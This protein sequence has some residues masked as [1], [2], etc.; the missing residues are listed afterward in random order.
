MEKKQMEYMQFKERLIET[1]QKY[2]LGKGE[3]Y[4]DKVKKT[5]DT[6]KEAVIVR[7]IGTAVQATIYPEDMYEGYKYT[8]DFEKCMKEV[9]RACEEVPFVDECYIPKTWESAK[10]RLHMRVI[11]RNW[12][13]EGL[14]RMP[15]R[16]YMDLA[17]VFY[18]FIK[19]EGGLMA[20]LP[21]S[22]E[23]MK[24]WGVDVKTLWE[25]S[26]K[27]LEEEVFRIESMEAAIENAMAE[28]KDAEI[29]E[30]FQND[31]KGMEMEGI[32]KIYVVTNQCR[33]YGARVILRKDLLRG[34]AKEQGGSFYILPCSV[35]EILLL[36]EDGRVTAENLKN[37]VYEIN[38]CSSTPKNKFL[39]I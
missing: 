26:R 21:V 31:R 22:R 27:N 13:K 24:L 7:L 35:H 23:C 16:E 1:L 25:A 5:N 28:M 6:D 33:N 20:T 12:N 36:K 19:E 8:G 29:E 4:Y 39:A 32:G 15:Y 9:I 18:V 10:S 3:V 38:H 11:N 30:M 37:M 14:K 2:F 17:I 34:L